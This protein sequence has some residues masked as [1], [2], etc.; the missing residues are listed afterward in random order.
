MTLRPAIAASAAAAAFLI[1]L[2]AAPAAASPRRHVPAP[3]DR[4]CPPSAVALGFSDGL[5][6]LSVAG[7]TVGGLSS[8]AYDRRS[9]A[10]ASAVDNHATDPARI[11]FFRNLADPHVVG[12]PLV[13]RRPDGTP[14]N[15]TDSDNEGLAV[16]P[17]GDFLVSSETEP[18]I[19]IFGRDGVQQAQLPVPARFA[20]APAGEATANATL[21]GL[22]ISP[23]GRRIVAAMEGALSGDNDPTLH[24]FLVYDA[25]RRGHRHSSGPVWRLSKQ[26]LYRAEPGQ[27]IPEVAALSDERLVVEEASFDPATGNA[28]TLYAASGLNHALLHKRLLADLVQC[29]TLGAT[30]KETQT[31]PLLDNFEGMAIT[32]P[33]RHG[34]FGLSLISDDNF[35]ATQTTRVLN[36]V[37]RER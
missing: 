3:N 33:E 15:G 8:L 32:T 2:G 16:L 22:T 17:D 13:L 7:A 9:H 36:L 34:R 37:L 21:E 5:D 24:R 10:W 11:W 28:V 26:V 18:S 25:V 27:R 23:S 14:Y 6:K 20:V 1:G 4:A 12:A 31:N 19:R 35:S 30:A 29:P